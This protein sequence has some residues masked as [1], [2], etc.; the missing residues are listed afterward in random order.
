MVDRGAT[1][2]AWIGDILL[3]DHDGRCAHWISLTNGVV[4]DIS[5]AIKAP[6]GGSEEGT[7]YRGI[8]S[9]SQRSRGARTVVL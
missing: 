8:A 9:T 4:H 1:L 2:L 3:A 5:S 6:C 7:R